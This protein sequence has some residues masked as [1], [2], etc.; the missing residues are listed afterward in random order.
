VNS[1]FGDAL[2]ITVTSSSGKTLVLE[3]LNFVWQNADVAAVQKTYDGQKGAIV[4]LFGWPYNDVAKE[5]V[6]LGK[7]GTFLLVLFVGNQAKSFEGYMGVKV[8]PPN[9]HIWGSNYYETDGQFRPWYL[10]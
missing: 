2:S 1:G 8:W 3:P 6:F 10:V 9:E 5:C 7:A 4:E